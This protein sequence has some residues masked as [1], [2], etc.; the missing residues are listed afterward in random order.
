MNACRDE[1]AQGHRPVEGYGEDNSER[2]NDVHEEE[3]DYINA[4]KGEW[5]EQSWHC[6]EH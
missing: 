5:E 2:F 4:P 6:P 3:I 1:K